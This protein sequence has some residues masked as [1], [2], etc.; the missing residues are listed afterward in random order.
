MDLEKVKPK[1][2]FEWYQDN[3]CVKVRIQ[4]SGTTSKKIDVSVAD[5]VLKINAMEVKKVVVFDLRH[6]VDPYSKETRFVYS[7]G[8]FEATLIK[9]EQ[10]KEWEN[11]LI[12]DMDKEEIKTRR[13]ESFKRQEEQH[14]EFLKNREKLRHEYDSKATREQMNQEDRVRD[15]LKNMKKEEIEAAEKLL[16]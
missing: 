6:E 15:M 7:N 5:L 11:L 3:K 14:Q 16:F 2:D 8:I 10:G 12:P 1:K 13:Q 9:K 4:I